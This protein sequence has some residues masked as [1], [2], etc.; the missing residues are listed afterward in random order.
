MLI[1]V[2]SIPVNNASCDVTRYT[3]LEDLFYAGNIIVDVLI[4]LDHPVI[5]RPLETQYG[6]DAEPFAIHS[7][8]GWTLNGPIT[9]QRTSKHLT[10]NFISAASIE[11]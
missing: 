6:S 3:H 2:D 8:L 5:L 4:G 9:S 11:H 7:I 1:V 10:S